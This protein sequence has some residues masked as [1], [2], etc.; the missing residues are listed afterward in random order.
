MEQWTQYLAAAGIAWFTG[1]FPMA[2]IY[3]AIP[4]AFGAGLDPLS[5]LFWTVLGNYTPVLIIHFGYERL[6]QFER[7]QRWEAKLISEKVKTRINQYG[8]LFVLVATPWI[9]VWVMT[10][11]AKLL[12]MNSYHFLMGTFASLVS[13]AIILVA[14]IQIGINQF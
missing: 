14:C 5:V 1:F 6:R 11:T 7:V 9:G 4:A 3:V 13:Y 10:F 8:L 2:E 12:N